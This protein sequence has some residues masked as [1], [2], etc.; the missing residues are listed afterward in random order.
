M[1]LLV[2]IK[3][4]IEKGVYL[5]IYKH[6]TEHEGGLSLSNFIFLTLMFLLSDSDQQH[7]I[8]VEAIFIY[9]KVLPLHPF[10]L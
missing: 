8:I 4:G 9:F 6:L 3:T 7:N 10:T 5:K 1:L 2:P